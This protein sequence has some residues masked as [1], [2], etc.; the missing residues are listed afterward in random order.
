M[1]Y[2]ICSIWLLKVAKE[3]RVQTYGIFNGIFICSHSIAI[4]FQEYGETRISVESFWRKSHSKLIHL[5]I[6]LWS[7]G[8]VAFFSNLIEASLEHFNFRSF[9]NKVCGLSLKIVLCIS[10][11]FSIICRL[12]L[13]LSQM[14]FWV[15]KVW[16]LSPVGSLPHHIILELNIKWI[17]RRSIIVYNL[18]CSIVWERLE[19][20]L[21]WNWK[22]R[23]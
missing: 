12:I 9:L 16:V 3:L 8:V 14:V 1:I 23:L 7:I 4:L 18:W 11:T 6:R 10:I 15:M 2:S 17:L 5:C 13:A 19:V 21:A 22:L 20:K